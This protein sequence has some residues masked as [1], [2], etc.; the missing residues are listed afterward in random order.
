LTVAAK[1]RLTY[2]PARPDAKRRI[3]PELFAVIR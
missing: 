2:R 1:A 3:S